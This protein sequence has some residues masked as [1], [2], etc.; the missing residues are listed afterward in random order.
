VSRTSVVAVLTT[1]VLLTA[2]ASLAQPQGAAQGQ[3]GG[4][5]DTKVVEQNIDADGNI[6]V[7]DSGT[8]AV[9]G[10][11]D[12][13]QVSVFGT[14]ATGSRF[15]DS[16]LVLYTVPAGK[17]LVVETVTTSSNTA[18]VDHMLDANF[19]LSL[20]G[21]FFNLYLQPAAEGVFTST[22][23]AIFRGT[24]KVTGYAGPG[25][26]VK[27]LATRDGASLSSTSVFFALSGHLIDAAQ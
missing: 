15:S 17:V 25:S 3:G 19:Q 16:G 8:V 27:V 10:T 24:Q 7:H 23:A 18:A 26:Q 14:F 2:H 11:L 6:R 12:P 4:K 20:N 9:K 21:E 13:V 1:A 5:P 22:S